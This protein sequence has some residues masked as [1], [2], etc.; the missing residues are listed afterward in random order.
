MGNDF[1]YTFMMYMMMNNRDQPIPIEAVI[2][3]MDVVPAPMRFMVQANAIQSVEQS[4]IADDQTLRSQ[5]SGLVAKHSISHR[6]LR[7]SYP[8][9][10]DLLQIPA[11]VNDTALAKTK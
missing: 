5:V 1:F 3:S 10:A 4:C 8:R 7:T 2:G 11:V 6:E 9:V